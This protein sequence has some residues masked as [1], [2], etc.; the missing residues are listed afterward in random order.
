M[1]L[2]KIPV[3]HSNVD[4]LSLLRLS[5][6]TQDQDLVTICFSLEEGVSVRIRI[7]LSYDGEPLCMTQAFHLLCGCVLHLACQSD[8]DAAQA[9]RD[10]ERNGAL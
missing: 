8:R 7:F 6:F 5:I 1:L 3:P 9:G 2:S 10:L 4:G